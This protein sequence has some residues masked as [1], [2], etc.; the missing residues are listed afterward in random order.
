[1]QHNRQPFSRPRN[2]ISLRFYNSHKRL[3]C[4]A[5]C[6]ANSDRPAFLVFN[7]LLQSHTVR[8]KHQRTR[9]CELKK[10]KRG[11]I[12]ASAGL[13]RTTACLRCGAVRVPA[14][15]RMCI[16]K[17][18][19]RRVFKVLC[20]CGVPPLA[21]RSPRPVASRSSLAICLHL[22]L[23]PISSRQSGRRLQGPGPIV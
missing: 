5:I 22:L 14:K 10:K 20:V 1:M 19:S 12:R 6:P 13:E 7:I 11:G 15:S 18:V 16:A 21:R 9:R 3:S 2:G 17:V 8:Y 23:S 4:P